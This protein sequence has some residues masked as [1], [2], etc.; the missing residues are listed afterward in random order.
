MDWESAHNI[1]SSALDVV[2]YNAQVHYEVGKAVPE[3]VRHLRQFSIENS[4]QE[5]KVFHFRRAVELNPKYVDA[6]INLGVGS[7]FQGKKEEAL[8]VGSPR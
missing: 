3:L 5:R 8:Q 1:F 7:S 6:L 4:L 2:P